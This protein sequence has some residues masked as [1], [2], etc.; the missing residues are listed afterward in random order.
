MIKNLLHGK[1]FFIFCV[2]SVFLFFIYFGTKA[3]FQ[4]SNTDFPNYY[5]SAKMLLKGNLNSAYNTQAFNLEIRKE[6]LNAQGL[7]VMYPPATSIVMTPLIGFSL[8]NAKKIWILFSSFCCI[9]IYL[10]IHFK[11]GVNKWCSLFILVGAGFNLANDL[12]LGQV[13]IFTVLLSLVAFSELLKN[14]YLLPGILF[15]FIASIKLFPILFLPVFIYKKKYVVAITLFSSFVFFNLI[16]FFFNGAEVFYSFIEAFNENYISKKVA[17]TLPT[18]TQYQ[19]IE[20]LK[21]KIILSNSYSVFIEQFVSLIAKTWSSIWILTI[22]IVIYVHKNSNHFIEISLSSI[23]LFLLITEVG[24]ASY[25]TLLLIPVLIMSLKNNYINKKANHL[26]LVI[27]MSMGYIPTIYL[28]LN[29]T[30]IVFDFN[31]LWMLSFFCLLFF[32]GILYS[33]KK[34]NTKNLQV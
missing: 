5:V 31:R 26:L 3:G 32:I 8:L 6:N 19:S 30:N 25:H 20:A 23:L 1:S 22:A 9:L 4:N 2:V 12:M 14:K 33:I 16:V 21:N 13:Y 15:G 7:F 17:G 24:S 10:I 27:W 18:S 34:G 11:F 29:L 28:K